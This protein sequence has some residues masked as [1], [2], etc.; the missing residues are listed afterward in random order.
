MS[1]ENLP[2]FMEAMPKQ[3]GFSLE[4]G[5]NRLCCPDPQ[6]SSQRVRGSVVFD[7][8]TPTATAAPR[9]FTSFIPGCPRLLGFASLASNFGAAFGLTVSTRPSV[10]SIALAVGVFALDTRAAAG[11]SWTFPAA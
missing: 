5:L 3:T 1:Q 9:L 4:N 2:V 6:S 10:L 8:H 11:F 7:K